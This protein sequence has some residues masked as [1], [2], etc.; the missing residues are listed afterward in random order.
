MQRLISGFRCFVPRARMYVGCV[1]CVVALI[2]MEL[3]V[4]ICETS[5]ESAPPSNSN[6]H[7][8]LA[9]P[10]RSTNCKEHP[11]RRCDRIHVSQGVRANGYHMC[12][13]H[14]MTVE[15]AS[16]IS[17]T[18]AHLVAATTPKS[19]RV[20]SCARLECSTMAPKQQNKKVM[21][22]KQAKRVARPVCKSFVL[23]L[24]GPTI[25]LNKIVNHLRDATRTNNERAAVSCC[26]VRPTPI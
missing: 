25:Y 13:N 19:T 6:S 3:P 4:H 17:L 7:E 21:M 12:A 5:C 9:W 18:R 24:F 10:S 26:C 20:L 14:K 8:R 11:V 2:C 22:V 15:N 1:A 16:P 23:V